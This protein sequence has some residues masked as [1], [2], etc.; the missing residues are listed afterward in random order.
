ML[1]DVGAGAGWPGIYLASSTGC[2]VVLTD[3]PLEGLQVATRRVRRDGVTGYAAG[4]SGDALPFGD[5]VFDAVTSSDVL[6]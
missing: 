4:A 3:I 2:E 6:C 5:S 1:L